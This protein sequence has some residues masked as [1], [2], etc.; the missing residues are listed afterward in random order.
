MNTDKNEN[1]TGRVIFGIEILFFVMMVV[2]V[3]GVIYFTAIDRTASIEHRDVCMIEKWDVKGP[4]GNVFTAGSTLMNETK[5]KGKFVMTGKLPDT[6]S[7]G[8]YFCAIIGGDCEVFI[9]GRLREVFDAKRDV[10]VPGGVVKRFY[11]RVPLTSA[12]SG[13]DIRMVRFGSGRVGY[14]YQDTFVTDD[15]AFFQ[16]MM[17]HYGLSLMLE[18]I[19]LIFSIVIT[20]AS[21]FMMI[22][23][24]RRIELLYGA[25]SVAVIAGWLITNSFLFP[26]L[27]GHYHIDGVF[28]YML[29]L[30]MPF[31]PAFYLNALQ[32]GRYRKRMSVAMAMAAASLVIFPVLHLT[33]V[34]SFPDAL[35]YIDILIGIELLIV[36]WLLI[37]DVIG[38]GVKDYKYTAIGFS[39]FFVCGVLEIIELNILPIANGDLIMLAG[40]VFMLTLI[41]VQ[42]MADLRKVR[43]EGQRA[44]DLSEAK[45]K[46]LASMS[47]EIRTPI[48]AI[49][50]MNEMILR[51]NRDPVIGEYAD[52]VKSSGQMLLMLVNDVLDFSKIEAGKM[53]INEAQFTFSSLLSNIMPMLKERAGEKQLILKTEIPDEVPDGMISDEFRIRQIL[54]N[55]INNAIKYTD[56]GSVTLMLGGEYMGE[57]AY[58]LRMRVKDT[59]RGISEEGQKDLFEAFSRAD[60]KKNRSIEGTGLGLAIVK[61]IV[62]SMGGEISVES[63]Y[64]EGSEFKVILPV[65]VTDRTPVD[66]DY[67]KHAQSTASD[68]G[69]CDYM[70][71]EASV[72]AVD[73]NNSNLKIVKLFLKRAGIVPELCD[74]G[75][76]AFELC[77]TKKYDLILLDHMMPDPDGIKTL[78]LI[79]NDEASLNKDTPAIVLTANAIAGSRKIY[80]DAGFDD[81]LTKPLDSA[82]LEQ[83]VK[84]YLP[85]EKILPVAEETIGMH[86]VKPVSFREK[87]EKI[88]GLDYDTALDYLG[89]DE[90]LLKEVVSIIIEECE[91]KS[92]GMREYVSS[93]DWD[94]YGI[95]AHAVKGLLLSIGLKDLSE[96]AKKHEFAARDQDIDF[97]MSDYEAFLQ[98]YESVCSQLDS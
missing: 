81:Y 73:D 7:D 28:N 47:H 50:G 67:E 91:E 16:Y 36:V 85:A 39:G 9:N 61:S 79:K 93:K 32:Q 70:A 95:Q 35:I 37:E 6:V 89:G 19:L 66:E 57:D 8:S 53:E 45:T 38:G 72:L 63:K 69:K 84:K 17:S 34:F 75:T 48:N 97:I 59:G 4:D 30:L 2:T 54:I 40:L 44:V 12:D 56:K 80:D 55:L 27:S 20:I 68:S 77:K 88:E 33:N 23:Y 71:P 24:R 74:N 90:D 87:L 18:I 5:T 65:R 83:T 14:I 51:E 46:F 92:N 96:R 43:E 52:S 29:C 26:F 64:G 10:V 62:D 31:C 22:H 86:A 42:Q 58:S 3:A 13:A 82:L 15:I 25:L 76:K 21:L 41:V 78:E 1:N 98:A 11:I 49:L 60:V 94:G